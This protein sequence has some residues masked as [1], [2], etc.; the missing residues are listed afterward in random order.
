VTVDGVD[1]FTTVN[2]PDLDGL[3]PGATDDEI[4]DGEDRVD[5]LGVTVEGVDAFV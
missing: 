3:V 2:I 5:R 1:M 4:V